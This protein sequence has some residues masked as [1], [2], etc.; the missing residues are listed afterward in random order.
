MYVPIAGTNWTS[1][2][3]NRFTTDT[4]GLVTFIGLED[5][6]VFVS[7]TAT[8]EKVGGGAD[9]IATRIAINGTTSAKTGGG[10]ESTA[11]TQTTSQGLFTLSTGDTIQL[12]AANTGSTA[13][14]T[15]TI[16]NMIMS[17]K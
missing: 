1:D 4:A 9:L 11:P 13:D 17:G 12:Y 5:E 16:A 15:V 2:V 6:D 10:T 7:A 3:E 8:L 14:I